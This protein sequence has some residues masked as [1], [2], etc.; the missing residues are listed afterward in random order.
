MG[1]SNGVKVGSPYAKL[2]VCDG[3]NTLITSANF[4]YHG[5][6]E[7][8]EIGVRIQ[9]PSVIRL[10]EFIEAMIRMKEVKVLH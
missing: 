8:I 2:L 5:L 4:S 9:S 6:H 7:N 1:L 3:L 10:V